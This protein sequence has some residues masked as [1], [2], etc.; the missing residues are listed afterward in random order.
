M[1]VGELPVVPLLLAQLLCGYDIPRQHRKPRAC[2][3]S[4]DVT[5]PGNGI[6]GIQRPVQ[7]GH[8]PVDGNVVAGLRPP[9]VRRFEDEPFLE[10]MVRIAGQA[11]IVF[12]VQAQIRCKG[13]GCIGP[14]LIKERLGTAAHIAVNERLDAIPPM[15]QRFLGIFPDYTT[16]HPFK[17]R[18]EHLEIGEGVARQR[19]GR[20][21]GVLRA[22]AVATD[23][24]HH[25]VA[26]TSFGDLA[27]T[28][29]A[30]IVGGTVQIIL[31]HHE[32]LAKVISLAALA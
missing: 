2:E 10:W 23:H 12:P 6:T 24:L 11:H 27:I 14:P 25:I 4:R 18:E 29:H 7:D 19:T 13:D 21:H 9:L 22:D 31:V 3:V 8:Q 32:H 26:G 1:V 28:V 5:A 20:R 30:D 15:G 16:H 17:F